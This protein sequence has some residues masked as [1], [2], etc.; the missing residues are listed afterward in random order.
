L[1]FLDLFEVA[2]I[3]EFEIKQK[4]MLKLPRQSYLPPLAC[5]P[6]VHVDCH[7]SVD[8]SKSRPC[9]GAHGGRRE[10]AIAVDPGL[11]RTGN[12]AGSTRGDTVSSSVAAPPRIGHRRV[13]GG[14]VPR[15]RRQRHG[16]AVLRDAIESGEHA[17]R[18]RSSPGLHRA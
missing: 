16:V 18:L 12:Q 14:E 7:V 2:A 17:R 6:V 1:N 4:E 9:P 3:D 11:A 5:G 13:T 15:W 10:S 8:W